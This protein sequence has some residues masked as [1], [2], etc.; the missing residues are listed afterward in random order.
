M[1]IYRAAIPVNHFFAPIFA[2]AAFQ[3]ANSLYLIICFLSSRYGIV[4][5]VARGPPLAVNAGPSPQ[6]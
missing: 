2:P 6:R 3:T 4:S 1:T 5:A